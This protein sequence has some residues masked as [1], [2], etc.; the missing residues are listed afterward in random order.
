GQA[1]LVA[2]WMLNGF[3]HGVMN[4][5]NTSISGETID[6]GPCA[7][8]D[9][10]HTDTVFSSIDAHKRY[11]FGQQPSIALWNLTRLAECLLPLIDPD[12]KKAVE[13]AEASLNGFGKM[14]NGYWLDGMRRK[15]GLT[16]AQDD[17]MTLVQELLNL[18]QSG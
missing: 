15:L 12:V 13:L 11:A 5:D 8:I 18:M 3:V 17:D 6:Y 14:F 7:F 4:T 10:Y 1:S 9:A 2:S 16:G